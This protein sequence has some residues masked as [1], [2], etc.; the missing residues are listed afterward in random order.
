M[1]ARRCH[2]WG[3]SNANQNL[4]YS[5]ISKQVFVPQHLISQLAARNYLQIFIIFFLS[6]CR[7]CL[8]PICLDYVTIA[9][10]NLANI[11]PDPVQHLGSNAFFSYR[12]SFV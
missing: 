11:P 2:L 9:C 4:Y 3:A 5:Y 7:L 12:K 1:Q 6:M 10:H 8:L